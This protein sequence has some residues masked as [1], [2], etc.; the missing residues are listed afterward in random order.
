VGP[1][2][3]PFHLGE[4]SSS[5]ENHFQYVIEIFSNFGIG[6]AENLVPEP[7]ELIVAIGMFSPVVSVSVY[8]DDEGA[9]AACE[10]TDETLKD[11]LATELHATELAVS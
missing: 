5:A 3:R 4:P 11:D 7:P 8:L 6:E 2:A 10:V 1:S 9:I